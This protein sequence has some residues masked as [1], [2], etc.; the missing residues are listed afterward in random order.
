MGEIATHFAILLRVGD[1][2]YCQLE[3]RAGG[4]TASSVPPSEVKDRAV[5][6]GATVTAPVEEILGP[7]FFGKEAG[8]EF[9][10][11]TNNCCNFAHNFYRAFC[12]DS[13]PF[14]A[15]KEIEET[16]DVEIFRRWVEPMPRKDGF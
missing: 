10:L 6:T 4:V 5:G 15:D 1:D 7:A 16:D 11:A 3:R 9:A 14:F 8:R 13:A 12:R 2:H